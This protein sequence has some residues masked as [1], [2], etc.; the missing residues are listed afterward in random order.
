MN[1]LLLCV[2]ALNQGM[3]VQTRPTNAGQYVVT[4]MKV[5]FFG[6]T[7]AEQDSIVR[8]EGLE[9]AKLFDDFDYYAGK[10]SAFLKLRGITVE[11]T[12]SPLILVA[13][14]NRKIRQID[15]RTSPNALGMILTDGVQEPRI[16]PP[17]FTDEELIA[18]CR[19]FFRLR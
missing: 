12:T 2:L 18:E 15:R 13:L 19:E 5:V 3:Q 16:V 7:Q 10:V 11:H 6:P 8:T 17:E 9:T 1:F 14:E 4:G